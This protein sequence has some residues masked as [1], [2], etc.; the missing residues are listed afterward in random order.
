MGLTRKQTVA[1]GLVVAVVG[2]AAAF[3]LIRSGGSGSSSTSAGGGPS[4]GGGGAAASEDTPRVPHNNIAAIYNLFGASA[5]DTR[6]IDAIEAR[7][8]DE[9]YDVSRR[10][11]D[12]TAGAGGQ[13]TATLKNFIKMADEASVIIINTHGQDFSGT[14]QSCAIGRGKGLRRTCG[15]SRDQPPPDDTVSEEDR[16]PAAPVASR[17]QPILQVE[18]YPKWKDQQAAL[19]RYLDEYKDASW[20]YDPFADFP[21]HYV[22]GTLVARRPGDTTVVNPDGTI[23]SEGGRPWLGITAAGIEHFFKGKQIDFIDDMACHSISLARSFDARAYFG[24]TNVACSPFEARDEITLFDRLIGES[25]VDA[26]ATDKA[27]ARGGFIDKFFALAPDSKPVVLS[28]AVKEVSPREGG[29]VKPGETT[30][31][32]ITFD[33][34]MN[35]DSADG[36]VSVSGCS[37][38]VENPKWNSATELKF[39]VTI[40]KD[41][42][43]KSMTVTVHHDKA[44]AEP[45]TADNHHLDGDQDPADKSGLAPNRDDY[46]YRLS[47]TNAA[48]LNVEVRYTGTMTANYTGGGFSYNVNFTWDEK[49]VHPFQF[50]DGLVEYLPAEP[51]TLT[52]SGMTTTSGRTGGP[53]EACTYTAAPAPVSTFQVNA[54]ED[55]SVTPRVRTVD[56][57]AYF[58]GSTQEGGGAGSAAAQLISSGSC[59]ESGRGPQPFLFYNPN[60]NFDPGGTLSR[61]QAATAD[62]VDLDALASS[63]H[64]VEFPFEYTQPDTGGGSDHVF[65]SATLTITLR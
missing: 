45:G 64:V 58:P 32:S 52:A 7:L 22:A 65:G 35:Q 18:W 14:T 27:F 41:Q 17:Q 34:E 39:D 16:V 29:V 44:L 38:K 57:L 10:Y 40:P 51:P 37:A 20:F 49:Q 23:N 15:G 63:P 13:G 33:A 26:R 9:G 46:V 59:L 12:K 50:T 42:T 8:K 28:P 43:E 2:G 25:G 3:G 1:T 30:A 4:G 47:C 5:D 48:V 60:G 11:E 24:H 62:G 54:Q 36:I 53:E 21:D 31:A 6:T 61:A 19:K 56:V 55:P